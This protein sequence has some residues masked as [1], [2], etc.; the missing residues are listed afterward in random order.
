LVG[1]THCADIAE[2]LRKISKGIPDDNN[3]VLE[4][5]TSSNMTRGYYEMDINIKIANKIKIP[6]NKKDKDQKERREKL[7]RTLHLIDSAGVRSDRKKWQ[8]ILLSQL[9]PDRVVEKKDKKKKKKKKDEDKDA[10][11]ST[12]PTEKLPI[13]TGV[14]ILYFVSLTSYNQYSVD[15]ILGLYGSTISITESGTPGTPSISISGE[16]RK[17]QLFTVEKPKYVSSSDYTSKDEKDEDETKLISTLTSP[18][19]ESVNLKHIDLLEK[20][21]LRKKMLKSPRYKPL[22]DSSSS[23][24]LSRHKS[25]QHNGL[26]TLKNQL[27]D[28]LEF[29]HKTVNMPEVENVPFIL[30]FTKKDLLKKKLVW[31]DL[32]DSYFTSLQSGSVDIERLDP[33]PEEIL[34][35]RNSKI[36]I[37]TVPKTS[38]DKPEECAPVETPTTTRTLEI[39]EEMQENATKAVVEEEVEDSSSTTSSETPSDEEEENQEPVVENDTSITVGTQEV[40]PTENQQ[41]KVEDKPEEE[42]NQE[43]VVENDTSINVGTKVE[44][45]ENQPVVQPVPEEPVVEEKETIPRTRSATALTIS[46][47][48]QMENNTDEIVTT[49]LNQRCV[50]VSI[51]LTTLEDQLQN[52]KK[53]AKQMINNE[54]S[55]EDNVS[56]E[57]ID[58]CLKFSNPPEKKVPISEEDFEPPKEL[59]TVVTEEYLDL[60]IKYIVKQFLNQVKNESKRKNIAQQTLIIDAFNQDE[61]KKH[62]D[63]I[64]NKKFN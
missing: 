27:L 32:S 37:S 60:N 17:S 31:C 18:L 8:K 4:Y 41:D 1:I 53:K 9:Y 7:F 21:R 54:A 12:A 36:D 47:S 42:K 49:T 33:F 30:V 35:K 5:L 48:P 25:L 22:I 3:H 59:P 55:P 62:L 52:Q 43:P 58:S 10:S 24:F 28:S 11:A 45:T 2:S 51:N 13:P 29:F 20:K 16:D 46:A 23:Q 63:D 19:G 34:N 57:M 38:E 6:S 61:M 44:P 50:S 26:L 39:P 14:A 40:E 64:L 56:K 15:D